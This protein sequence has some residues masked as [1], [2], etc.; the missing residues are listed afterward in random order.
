[1][2]EQKFSKEYLKTIDVNEDGYEY[3]ERLA[4]LVLNNSNMNIVHAQNKARKEIRTRI[5]TDRKTEK[6]KSASPA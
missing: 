6:G 1:M 4:I 5:A 3:L 2:A